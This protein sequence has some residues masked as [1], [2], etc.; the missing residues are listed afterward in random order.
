[1][2]IVIIWASRWFWK[3]LANFI[4]KQ[5]F[6]NIEIVLT[7]REEENLKQISKDL[8]C[9]YSLDNIASV[10]DADVVIFSV[11][12]SATE[13]I[14]KEV[15]PHIKPWAMVLD[16]TSIKKFP[17]ITMEKYCDKSCLIVPT[18]PMF[19]PFV[20][21]IAGQI[22]VLTPLNEEDKQDKRYQ[23]LFNFLKNAWAK[24]MET[25]PVEHDKMMA[26]V[27]GLTHLNMFVFA[28]TIKRLWVDIENS[29]E[30]VSPVYKIMLSSVA[31]YMHQ[32]PKLYWDIQMYNDE[33]LN[34]HKIYREVWHDFSTL[35]K[36]HNEEDFIKII[37]WTK[38]YFWDNAIAW[39]KYTDKIIYMISRQVEL[40]KNN[41]NK[42][43]KLKNIYD[44]RE[45]FWVLISFENNIIKLDNRE[46]YNIDEWEVIK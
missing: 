15:A 45:V 24:V 13:W 22:I 4:T 26:V 29:L 38:D 3:W 41:I 39:Q 35:V 30:F 12:I 7:W 5:N 6:K 18:H 33:V 19:W 25:M 27:Q 11:P 46:E 32:N 37:E 43:V 20:S 8:N 40:L 1:M 2:K 34:V 17:S 44:N 10:K 42:E 23:F 14:I 31:R 9:K 16:V 36:A 28:E 21:S